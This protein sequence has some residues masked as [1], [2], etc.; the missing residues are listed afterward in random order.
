MFQIRSQPQ[1]PGRGSGF[2]GATLQLLSVV[3]GVPGQQAALTFDER[4]FSQWGPVA[5]LP[6][7]FSGW[8]LSGPGGQHGARSHPWSL[9]IQNICASCTSHRGQ[10]PSNS[11]RAW[12]GNS[13]PDPL[14][15]LSPGNGR[16]WIWFVF[17]GS[18]QGPE[19][20]IKG[21]LGKP[22]RILTSS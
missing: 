10:H 3:L 16:D 20:M 22:E 15:H 6:L 2:G 5:P 21:N 19:R 4:C 13:D 14:S 11:L 1:A 17:E 12:A 18:G 9:W 7:L 8:G